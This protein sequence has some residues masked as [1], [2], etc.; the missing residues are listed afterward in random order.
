[1]GA[2]LVGTSASTSEKQGYFTT[3]VKMANTKIPQLVKKPNNEA[4]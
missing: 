3:E 2:A 1:M 4:Q